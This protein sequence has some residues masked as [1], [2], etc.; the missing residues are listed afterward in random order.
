MK[1]LQNY[2]ILMSVYYKEN[3]DFLREAMMSMFNQTIKTNDFVLVC[4]GPITEELKLVIEEMKNVF[5]NTLNVYHLKKNLGLGNALNYGLQKCKNE[6]VARMDSDDVSL[7]DR[8]EKQLKMLN[9]SPNLSII[10][11]TVNEFDDN[12]NLITGTR[13]V[14]KENEQIIEFSKSRN[15]FNHPAVMLKKSKVELVGGYSERFPLFED[16]YLWLRM[17]MNGDTG[18][19]IVEP[20]VLMRVPLDLYSR[21]GGFKYAKNFLN[22]NIWMFRS[23]WIGIKEVLT[24]V[25]PHFII[26]IMPNSIRSIIYKHLH[27]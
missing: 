23:R 2:S 26:C 12:C 1:N 22:L 21:R 25:F 15:P 18:A 16:Y 7:P 8:I 14:P 11:G 13:K 4:D 27:K 20:I 6:I 24:S 9:K 19:N 5:G 3:P 17:L 10:S